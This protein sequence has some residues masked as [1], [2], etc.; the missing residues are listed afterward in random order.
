[1]NLLTAA[2]HSS[3]PHRR[4]WRIDRRLGVNAVVAARSAHLVS[5]RRPFPTKWPTGECRTLTRDWEMVSA[6]SI[7]YNSKY[8]TIHSSCSQVVRVNKFEF[9]KFNGS[10]WKR[11]ASVGCAGVFFSGQKFFNFPRLSR[12]VAVQ[13]SCWDC[14]GGGSEEE[15]E[16]TRVKNFSFFLL[17]LFLFLVKK[18]LS[19]VNGFMNFMLLLSSCLPLS[20]WNSNSVAVDTL[21]WGHR[22]DMKSWNFPA[23]RRYLISEM[24][25]RATWGTGEDFSEL[26]FSFLYSFFRSIVCIQPTEHTE[27]HAREWGK[28]IKN[29]KFH[30]LSSC[31]HSQQSQQF[32]RKAHDVK[33]RRISLRNFFFA[34]AMMISDAFFSRSLKFKHSFFTFHNSSLPPTHHSDEEAQIFADVDDG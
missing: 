6:K 26:L 24:W 30:F 22:D 12:A 15:K 4:G 13:Y 14:V 7:K 11:R 33:T 17:F 2:V 25:T 5:P 23:L 32:A 3:S 10:R 20:R 19:R 31:R 27:T 8:S 16:L 1:M 34:H 9:C 28:H 29:E 21:N 18:L